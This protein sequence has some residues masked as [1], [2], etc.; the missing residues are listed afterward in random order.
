MYI[1]LNSFALILYPLFFSC[2]YISPHV[3]V[4]F[5]ILAVDLGTWELLFPQVSPLVTQIQYFVRNLRLD[6]LSPLTLILRI[7]SLIWS[8]K[9]SASLLSMF[10][11]A[12]LLPTLVWNNWVTSGSF[13]FLRSKWMRKSFEQRLVFSFNLKFHHDKITIAI[14]DCARNC[15]CVCFV[16]YSFAESKQNR[17]SY[18]PFH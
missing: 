7:S 14:V 6:F 8:P 5:L 12:N 2:P 10:R 4:H 9:V 13:S 11:T 18:E 15:P 17:S 16:I 1:L 3:T